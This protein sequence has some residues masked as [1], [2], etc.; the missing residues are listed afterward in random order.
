MYKQNVVYSYNKKE[1]TTD[2]FYNIHELQNHY[3]RREMSGLNDYVLC[4][5]IYMKY[6]EKALL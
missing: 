1:Q 5:A 2:I 3:A 6:T 4:D